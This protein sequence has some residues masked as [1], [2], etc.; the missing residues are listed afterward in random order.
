MVLGIPVRVELAFIVVGSPNAGVGLVGTTL[1]ISIRIGLA[2]VV[3]SPNTNFGPAYPL[4][5]VLGDSVRRGLPCVVLFASSCGSLFV[6]GWP[7]SFWGLETL[8]WV[9]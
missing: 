7:A 1:G 4:C 9:S 5:V 2:A 3:R 8:H 6:V